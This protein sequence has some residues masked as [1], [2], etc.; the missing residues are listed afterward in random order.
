MIQKIVE[1]IQNNQRF[2]VVAHE[3]P[4]GDA[5]GSTLGLANALRGMGK[6]VVALNVDP[7]PAVMS[8]LPVQ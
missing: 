8:F 4:D 1:Q 6:D 7:V 3:N 5:I 2:L